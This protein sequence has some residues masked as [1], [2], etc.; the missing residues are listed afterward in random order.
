MPSLKR[1][2][3]KTKIKMPKHLDCDYI[4]EMSR[5]LL[6]NGCNLRVKYNF[7]GRLKWDKFQSMKFNK[8]DLL[9]K[10]LFLFLMIF[11]SSTIIQ[12]IT[13]FLLV[14]TF[15]IVIHISLYTSICKLY[16]LGSRHLYSILYPQCNP[17]ITIKWRMHRY[18]F[19]YYFS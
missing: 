13:F 10:I 18:V 11:Y 9:I 7:G 8:L 2:D 5:P 15:F 6:K 14:L 12:E 3:K 19:K 16:N 4:G 17:D 1:K